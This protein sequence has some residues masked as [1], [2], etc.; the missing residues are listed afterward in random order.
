M[1]LLDVLMMSCGLLALVSC[2]GQPTDTNETDVDTDTTDTDDTT[3]T[4]VVVTYDLTGSVFEIDS[5]V[6]FTITLQEPYGDDLNMGP[7]HAVLRF[8]EADGGPADG[9]AHLTDY[10]MMWDFVTG[11]SGLAE[12]HTQLDNT[13]ADECGVASGTLTGTSLA[14][15]PGQ[16]SSVCQN[17]QISCTGSFCGMGGSPDEGTP[18]VYTDDC[19]AFGINDLTLSADYSTLDMPPVT[20][21]D[22]STLSLHGTQVELTVDTQTPECI[23]AALGL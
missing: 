20:V 2:G 19:E 17:G 15:S 12:V 22:E 1:R 10:R 6:D 14:W 8:P 3:C 7:G 9:L 13:A 16:I 21:S 11:A 4:T 23:C 18:V 5:M